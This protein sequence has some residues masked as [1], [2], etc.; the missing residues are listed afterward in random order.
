MKQV[1]AQEIR[2][3]AARILAECRTIAPDAFIGREAKKKTEKALANF[4]Q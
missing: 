1:T 2:R 4:Q 3:E